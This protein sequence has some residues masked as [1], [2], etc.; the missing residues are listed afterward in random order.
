MPGGRNSLTFAWV[1]QRAARFGHQRPAQSWAPGIASD[2]LDHFGPGFGTQ[3][4]VGPQ[5]ARAGDIRRTT[6]EPTMSLIDTRIASLAGERPNLLSRVRKWVA[7][8]IVKICAS[9]EDPADPT[10]QFT[11]HERADLPTHHPDLDK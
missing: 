3:S 5:F 11:P 1:P 8:W 7:D 2:V 6:R 10:A 9:D 4:G